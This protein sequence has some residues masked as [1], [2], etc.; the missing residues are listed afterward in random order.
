MLFLSA[1]K[2]LDKK[3]TIGDTI[4]L[5]KDFLF[6]TSLI[7]VIGVYGTLVL[8]VLAFKLLFAVCI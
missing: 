4:F 6:W 2:L 1:K 5:P 3:I 8:Q 7:V